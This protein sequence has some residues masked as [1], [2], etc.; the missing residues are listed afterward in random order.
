MRG[1]GG[2]GPGYCGA[3]GSGYGDW[4]PEQKEKMGQLNQKFRDETGS[5]RNEM[6]QKSAEMDRLMDSAEPDVE[7]LKSLQKNISDLRAQMAQKRL[8]F[9]LEARKAL[10]EGTYAGGYGR[11]SKKGYGK[12]SRR[13]YGRGRGGYGQG[14]CWQ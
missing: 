3:Y 2:G 5:L 4:T 11:G 1:Y 7:K 8:D 10:P 13:G 9:E 6:W 14:G 12:D